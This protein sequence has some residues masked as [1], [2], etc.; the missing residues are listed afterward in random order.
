MEP[1]EPPV[2]LRTE[3]F[4]EVSRR[5][6]PPKKL[7]DENE[8]FSSFGEAAYVG[9]PTL[10]IESEPKFDCKSRNVSQQQQRRS[11]SNNVCNLEELAV[12]LNDEAQ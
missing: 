8:D 4:D 5:N 6:E 7:D 3:R 9:F 1:E 2:F 12:K 11:I 10:G